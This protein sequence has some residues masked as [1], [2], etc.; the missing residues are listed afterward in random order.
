MDAPARVETKRTGAGTRSG[1][2]GILM[3]LNRSTLSVDAMLTTVS[4]STTL[5]IASRPRPAALESAMS[6][7][8]SSQLPGYWSI[9][10]GSGEDHQAVIVYE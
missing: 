8:A 4:Q 7:A 3:N 2:E 5:Y 1:H 10:P 6:P 9:E